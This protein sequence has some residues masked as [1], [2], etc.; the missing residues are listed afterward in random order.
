MQ[1]SIKYKLF[2][3]ILSAH[4]IVYVAM[5]SIG[6]YSFEQ[7]FIEYI[8]RIEQQQ[9]P[10]LIS[11]LKNFYKHTGSWDP[12]R[13]DLRKFGDLIAESIESTVDPNFDA[14]LGNQRPTPVRFSPNDWYYTSEYSPARPYLALLDADQSIIWGSED[15]LPEAQLNPIIVRG[16]TV[17]FLS[18]TNR[19]IL[20]EQADQLFSE[21]QK[22]SFFYLALLLSFISALIAFPLSTVMVKPIMAVVQGTRA[23]TS[24]DYSSRIPVKGSD[25]ISQLA[26]NFNDLANTL[27]QNQTA[28]EQW[29]ADISH[30]LRT[31]LSILQGELESMQDGVRPVTKE[32]LDSLHH[33]I[34]HLNALVN[35]LHELSMSDMGA[36]I[37]EKENIDISRVL[38]FTLDLHQ[39][40]TENKGIRINTTINAI[41][42]NKKVMLFADENRLIQLF[43]NLLQNTCRYT[44]QGG[45]LN[46]SLRES[47][48]QVILIWSDSS[49]GV[50]D[51]DL[52]QLFD[53]LYRVESSRN[54]KNGGSGLG[55]AI[56][57]NI[58]E[59]HDGTINAEHS[60]MGGLKLT[61]RFPRQNHNR[62][63]K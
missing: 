20:S 33:E 42:S 58:I 45:E 44:D 31:P 21:Q 5:Y 34:V 56:C 19:Q 10:A 54:R 32:T 7:G 55:L 26:E 17:G 14:A 50:K 37:Y 28:R 46:I 25:E 47:G 43:G 22:D 52:P 4:I 38:N 11:G 62:N 57:K 30:E 2:F 24:G 15:A 63:Q 1:L 60:D 3:A 18:V 48:D 13:N 6:R 41:S 39:Q 59:A 40:Q 51:E 12:I 23:L 29:I 61:I 9:V 8:S 35:D 27:D 53:R 36:L 16:E 49:P